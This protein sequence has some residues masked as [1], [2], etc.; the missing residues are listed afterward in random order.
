MEVVVKLTKFSVML[1]LLTVAACAPQG[2]QP[3]P[4]I[5]ASSAQWDEALNTGDIEK[6]VSYYTDDCQLLPPNGAMGQGKDAVRAAFG[7]MISA[8]LSG[9]TVVVEAT[10]AGDLGHKIGTF[11]ILAPNGTVID[12]GKFIETWRKTADGWKISNDIWNSD[13]P[14]PFSGTVVSI[15]HEVKDAEVW[16]AAWTGPDGR[17]KDFAENGCGGVRVFQNP[18]KPKQMSLLVEVHDM[19]EFVGW[20]TSEAS[21]AAKAEDGVI[22]STLKFHTEVK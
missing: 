10:S 11:S 7:A 9:E 20:V 1:L 5:A 19:E 18:E 2:A 12:R 13:N 21:Q 15:A 14:A 3:N 6:L 4:E 17:K 8:G 16:L 22:D